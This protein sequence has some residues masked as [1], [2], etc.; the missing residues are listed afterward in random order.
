MN[1]SF[2]VIK[3]FTVNG[4]LVKLV[5]LNPDSNVGAKVYAN[6]DDDRGLAVMNYLMR[7]GMVSDSFLLTK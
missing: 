3:I 4:V 2:P 5:K 1:R 7:E 6:G